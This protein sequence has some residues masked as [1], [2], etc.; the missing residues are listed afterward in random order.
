MHYHEEKYGG[1]IR[2][3]C[4]YQTDRTLFLKIICINVILACVP[5]T[6]MGMGGVKISTAVSHGTGSE[7]YWL[8]FFTP[9]TA[10]THIYS[11]WLGSRM[12]WSVP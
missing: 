9:V 4:P 2:V 11:D 6:K 8:Q 3:N 1:N 12:F 10:L 7:T 5:V